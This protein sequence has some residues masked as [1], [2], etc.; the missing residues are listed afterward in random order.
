MSRIVV[1]C[2]DLVMECDAVRGFAFRLGSVVYA[3]VS[4]AT[5]IVT[6]GDEINL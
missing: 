6:S 1:E 5:V 2:G 4:A 3:L